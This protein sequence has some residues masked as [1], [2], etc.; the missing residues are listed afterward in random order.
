[1]KVNALELEK[2]L[3]TIIRKQAEVVVGSDDF[4]GFR[5]HNDETRKIADCENRI[6]SLSEQRQDCY[7]R[8]MGGEIVRDTFMALKDEY[9]AQIESI[10]S[11]TALLR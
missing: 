11:Q 4:T 3:L 6:K 8:F 7:E 2:T 1:M 10:N 5:K 9:T